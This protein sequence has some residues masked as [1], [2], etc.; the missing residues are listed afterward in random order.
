[1]G[2]PLLWDRL[3]RPMPL[4]PPLFSSTLSTELLAT[5]S[6]RLECRVLLPDTSMLLLVLSMFPSLLPPMLL[7]LPRTPRSLSPLPHQPSLLPQH[8]LLPSP[9]LPGTLDLPPLTPS[10]SRRSLPL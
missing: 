4:V 2:P 9:L 5:R 7:D 1:M 6:S 8:P 3:T 10:H